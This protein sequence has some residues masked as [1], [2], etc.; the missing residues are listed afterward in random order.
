MSNI[1]LISKEQ[2][3]DYSIMTIK[4]VLQLIIRVIILTVHLEKE[5]WL[6]KLSITGIPNLKRGILFVSYKKGD[7]NTLILML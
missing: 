3:E 4:M 1:P 5:A 6:K 2:I 7:S